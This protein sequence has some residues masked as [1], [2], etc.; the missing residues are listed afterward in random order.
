[1][2]SFLGLEN[3]QVAESQAGRRDREPLRLLVELEPWGRNF[4]RNLGDFL[5]RRKP[6]A[7][8]TTSRPAPFWPDVFVT[9]RPAW[10]AFVESVLYHLIVF[11]VAWGVTTLMPQPRRV[12]QVRRFDPKD[13][14][15]YSP[16][17]YLPPLDTGRP[18]AAKPV[19][20][21]PEFAKQPILSVPPEADN[22]RQTIVTPPDIKIN[23]DIETPNIVAWG[24]HSVPVP[25]A[26]V[27]R[28]SL[29]LPLLPNQIVAPAPEV[30]QA[31]RG[32]L[33]GLEQGVVSPPP[34]VDHGGRALASMGMDVVAP[35][36][37]TNAAGQ[38][39]ALSGPESAVVAP[40]PTTDAAA[41]R[42]LGDLNVGRSDV[43]VP[44]PQLPVSA[45]RTL[46]GLG[47]AEGKA[48]VPP[49]PSVEGSPAA[50]GVSSRAARATGPGS[51]G[52]QVVPPPPGIAGAHSADAGGHIIALSLNPSV[53][54]PAEP[55]VGNRR[56]TFAASFEG[57]A[58]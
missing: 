46:P 48:V 27:E 26:A 52:V 20:G 54:P 40:P 23:H 24:N 6:P 8:Q 29:N 33:R 31:S 25:G 58:K 47:G 32:N 53:T 10:G 37:D 42:R 12:V 7:M 14:I 43:I 21:H 1:M 57:K 16:S 9:Q 17:E 41:I 35:A 51:P 55:P 5:L 19:K 3:P 38:R 56:G 13:V 22:R 28:K 11:A 4:R 18:T 2:T 44:A 30:D 50:G 34:K 36:P 15:Y 49:P 45:Q 39:R